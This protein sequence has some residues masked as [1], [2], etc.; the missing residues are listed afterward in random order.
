MRPTMALLNY[1]S[2]SLSTVT[3]C[4]RLSSPAVAASA[5]DRNWPPAHAARVAEARSRGQPGRRR[6]AGM[7]RLLHVFAQRLACARARSDAGRLA[8]GIELAG[9]RWPRWAIALLAVLPV[10]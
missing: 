3:R 4:W 9:F 6:A 1:S 8:W 5:H 2:E 7:R 10:A